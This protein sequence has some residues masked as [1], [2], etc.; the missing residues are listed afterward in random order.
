MCIIV[1]SEKG[2]KIPSKKTLET[3]FLNNPDGA[4]I[5]YYFDNSVIV[6]K[7]YM[8]FKDFY[9]RVRELEKEIGLTDRSVVFH[10]RIGTSGKNDAKTCHPYPLTKQTKFLQSKHV[11]CSVAMAHNGILSNFVDRTNKDNLNDTQIFI[12]KFMYNIYKLSKNFYYNEY[13]NEL[14][15][16]TIATNRLCFLTKNDEIFYY[17]NW[18]EDNGIY[19]SNSNYKPK[20]IQ[21]YYNNAYSRYNY[22]NDFDYYDNYW[23][24]KSKTKPAAEVA[25]T[26]PTAKKIFKTK[27]EI[28]QLNE[29]LFYYVNIAPYDFEVC[30]SKMCI[31]KNNILYQII[32]DKNPKEIELKKIAENVIIY[33]NDYKSLSF[34]FLKAGGI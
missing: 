28:A 27:H 9:K 34:D 10:F 12:Q 2:K 4:G 15:F 11:R 23:K 17:G 20:V 3:C 29:N 30:T 13:A 16:N 7:G 33:N 31:D 19:Y 8:T 21:T 1:A 14:I 25:T 18:V 22:Y 6:D 26:K 32:N 24:S 5:M